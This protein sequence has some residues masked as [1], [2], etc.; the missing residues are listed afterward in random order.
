M[1]WCRTTDGGRRWEFGG[2]LF[3]VDTR[4][5]SDI[6]S[7]G[8]SPGIKSTD[9]VAQRRRRYP[10]ARVSETFQHSG[11]AIY[12]RADGDFPSPAALTKYGCTQYTL[13]G[14]SAGSSMS[15]LASPSWW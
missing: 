1:F 8:G 15:P 5:A 13:P 3:V 9:K 11:A 12:Y 4:M 10:L 2:W 14:G 6:P 7:G